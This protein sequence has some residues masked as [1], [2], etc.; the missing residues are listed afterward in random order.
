MA[1]TETRSI[2]HV[3]D[4]DRPLYVLAC[5]YLEAVRMYYAELIEEGEAR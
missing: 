3:Q 4:S 5:G 1:K 2:Y